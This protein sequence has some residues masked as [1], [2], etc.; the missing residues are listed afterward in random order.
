VAKKWE[1]EFNQEDLK[2]YLDLVGQVFARATE[3]LAKDVWGNI[4]REAPTR[5]GK[6]AG[7]F[8]LERLDEYSWMISSPT[9][10]A[11]FVHEGTG[12]Y[13]PVGQRIVPK[14]ARFL[15]FEWKGRTWF[16][17]SVAG[18]RPNPYVDRAMTASEGRMREF[19]NMAIAQVGA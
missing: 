19:V 7:S 5:H 16:L 18:Q 13:G 10:Y 17:K 12:I 9:E 3:N 4:G 15:V 2:R 1:V 6:L 8:N 11:L 14:R